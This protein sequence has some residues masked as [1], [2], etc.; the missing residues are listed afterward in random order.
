MKKTNLKRKKERKKERK[1]REGRRNG[2]SFRSSISKLHA[3]YS[4]G[5]E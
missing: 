5:I 4:E 1:R 2:I 3:V